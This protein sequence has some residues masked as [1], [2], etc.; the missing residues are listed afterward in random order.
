MAAVTTQCVRVGADEVGRLPLEVE[1]A[2]RTVRFAEWTQVDESSATIV[3]FAAQLPEGVTFTVEAGERS[4]RSD[5]PRWLH[6][7]GVSGP[8]VHGIDAVTFCTSGPAPVLAL[9]D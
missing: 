5:Q 4:F 8:R 2:G 3:G 9:A 7:A 6:P 1:L